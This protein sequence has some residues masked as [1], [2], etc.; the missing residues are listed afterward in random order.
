M[1]VRR[2]PVIQQVAGEDAD[3]ASRPAWQWILIGSGLLVTI[4]APAVALTLLVARKFAGDDAPGAGLAGGLV[5]G[6][7]ALA[8]LAAGYLVGRF[9]ARTRLRHAVFAGLSAALEIWLIALLGAAFSSVLLAVSALVSLAA[10]AGAFAAMGAWLSRRS[11][12]TRSLSR[13]SAR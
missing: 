2:L 1:A 12:Q 8:A 5:A 4:W 7:F 10:L 9:G 3:A 13:E 6:S 11:S